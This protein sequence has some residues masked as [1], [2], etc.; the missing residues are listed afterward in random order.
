[1]TQPF[2][3]RERGRTA[4]RIAIQNRGPALI[5]PLRCALAWMSILQDTLE[6]IPAWVVRVAGSALDREIGVTAPGMSVRH[7]VA[8]GAH[9]ACRASD[10]TPP[11]PGIGKASRRLR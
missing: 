9:G 3:G 8:G 4:V 2:C 7:D 11:V 1:M 5:L 6:E 10:G